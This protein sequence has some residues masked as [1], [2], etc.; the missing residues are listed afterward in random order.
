MDWS[1]RIAELRRE[2][3]ELNAQLDSTHDVG[4]RQLLQQKI[5]AKLTEV[6]D[7]ESS[8]SRSLDVPPHIR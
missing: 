5:Q 1:A 6:A 2:I 8:M 3:T 7:L 4:A